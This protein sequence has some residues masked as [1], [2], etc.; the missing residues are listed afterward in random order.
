MPPIIHIRRREAGGIDRRLAA[1]HAY[2]GS[3]AVASTLCGASPTAYD[4]GRKDAKHHLQKWVHVLKHPGCPD[5]VR[6][7]DRALCATCRERLIDQIERQ[8]L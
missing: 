6:D 2:P 1:R 5:F 4:T 7:F 3:N 8:A